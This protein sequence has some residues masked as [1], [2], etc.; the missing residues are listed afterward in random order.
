MAGSPATG[1]DAAASTANL[2]LGLA[3]LDLA[4]KLALEALHRGVV[5]R[6]KADGTIVT[7]ADVAVER[8]IRSILVRER[9]GDAFLG[10]EAGSSGR[11]PRRWIVD[12]IDRTSDF[13]DG[14]PDWGTLIALEERGE[15]T[16][17][18]AGSPALQRRW[19][20]TK[21]GRAFVS[22]TDRPHSAPHRLQ[23][24]TTSS[25]TEAVFAISPPL[26]SLKGHSRW[27]AQAL[28]TACGA[29][30]HRSGPASPGRRQRRS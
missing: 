15:I 11:G 8:A 12:G 23:V 13:V 10:E 26:T 7:D 24:S 2:A 6:G 18:V 5:A 4:R 25:L 9:P 29:S 17:A 1:N 30:P 20:A 16:L 22:Q 27:V 21:A 19:W 3:L 14:R 28:A